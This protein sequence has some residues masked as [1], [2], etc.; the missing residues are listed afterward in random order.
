M[1][2]FDRL[3]L[4]AV[5][6]VAA[7]LRL[8]GI[9]A[10]GRFDADQGHD[11]LTLVAFTRDGV[12]PLLGPKTSVG[13][14]HHGAYYFLLAPAAAVSNGDPV[15]VTAFIALL[16]D[17]RGRAHVV[18]RPRAI[19]G[20]LAGRS[21][22]SCSRSRRPA[23]ESRR[24]SG[25]QSDRFF[26]VLSLAAAWRAPAGTGGGPAWWWAVA[27]GAPGRCVQLHVLGSSSCIA[28]VALAL[29][30][31]RRDAACGAGHARRLGIVACF[32]AAD[33][34]TSSRTGSSRRAVL[35]YRA[36]DA[37]HRALARSAR[38]VRALRVV[39]WPLVGLVTDIPMVVAILLAVVIG[40]IAVGL[41]APAGREARPAIRWLVGTWPG[42]RWRSRSLRHR[43]SAS[44]PGSR[45]TTTTRSSTRSWSS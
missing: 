4:L 45:T 40:L 28:I 8:P 14:F 17:R 34:A 1:S 42:A 30:E 3:S 23:I 27:L 31:L 13:E 41:G 22:G 32:P 6:G 20:P 44:W 16:G 2:R 15:A 21:P 11:M 35:D 29:L 7:L 43:S 24:S 33:R 37:A 36:G 26:A 12:V 19:G 9:E 18:A 38:R 10:R 39:G 25:T 5:V